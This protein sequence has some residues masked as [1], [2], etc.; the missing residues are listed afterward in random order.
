MIDHVGLHARK[1]VFRVSEQIRLKPACSATE[2]M[3]NH[4]KFEHFSLSVLKGN[5]GYQDWNVRVAN[6]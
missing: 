1:P 2:A 5:V 6:R 3:V 4:L